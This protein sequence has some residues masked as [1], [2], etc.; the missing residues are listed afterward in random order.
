MAVEQNRQGLR[1]KAAGRD[2]T[3]AE[4]SSAR[5]WEA[6]A[7]WT[8]GGSPDGVDVLRGGRELE[9]VYPLLHPL[10]GRSLREFFVR[11]AALEALVAAGRAS[12]SVTDLSEALYL[13]RGDDP[14]AA[15]PALPR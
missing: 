1:E 3:E 8:G 10:V 15:G 7:E 12:F 5:G 14:R 2:W 11:A 13:L 6:I 9:F 4:E